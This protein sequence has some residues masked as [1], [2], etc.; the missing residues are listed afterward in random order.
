MVWL[1]ICVCDCYWL[2]HC[3]LLEAR[4]IPFMICGL[5][6]YYLI[7]DIFVSLFVSYNITTC[8]LHIG[9]YVRQ[10]TQFSAVWNEHFSGIQTKSSNSLHLKRKT[11]P[12]IL[13][14]LSE[15]LAAPER[16]CTH[17][18]LI[19]EDSLF[20]LFYVESKIKSWTGTEFGWKWRLTKNL[21]EW[22]NWD[23]LKIIPKVYLFMS[24]WA[25]KRTL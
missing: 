13:N 8:S 12:N 9:Y 19:I 23:Y 11:I 21:P 4:C 20:G 6:G 10:V 17:I 2:R 15:W 25:F 1:W 14:Q 22:L 24:S 16:P 3:M 7:T 5:P 18:A